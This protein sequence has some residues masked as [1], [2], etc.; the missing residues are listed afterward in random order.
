MVSV[1]GQTVIAHYRNGSKPEQ[2]LHVWSVTK[3][4]ISVL[5]GIAISEKIISGLDQT[6]LELLPNYQQYMKG[7]GAGNHVRQLMDMTAG[8]PSGDITSRWRTSNV[9]S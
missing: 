8:F 4:V 5:I 6:L 2:A 1:D 3:S 7:G 9:F